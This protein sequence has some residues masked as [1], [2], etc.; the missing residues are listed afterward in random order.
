MNL[1]EKIALLGSYGIT[2]KPAKWAGPD[3]WSAASGGGEILDVV[4]AASEEKAADQLIKFYG[5]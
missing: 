2:I 4:Y 3:A 1:D 5:L